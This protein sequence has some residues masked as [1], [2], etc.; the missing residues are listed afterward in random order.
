MNILIIIT[1]VNMSI[2]FIKFYLQ[3]HIYLLLC[4]IEICGSEEHEL[5]RIKLFCKVW[6]PFVRKFINVKGTVRQLM[7]LRSTLEAA[8]TDAGGRCI[9][10]VNA[11]FG[12]LDMACTSPKIRF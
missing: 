3:K 10:E 1:N 4:A 9:H 7:I 6:F 12:V 2:N 8:I 5:K 11:V